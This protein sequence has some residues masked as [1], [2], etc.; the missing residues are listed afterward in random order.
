M[1]MTLRTIRGS[2]LPETAMFISL[3][4]LLVLGAA[5]LTLVG[6][7]QLSAD[8]A[9][10]LGAHAAASN[11]NA[12]PKKVITSIFPQIAASGV[13]TTSPS[14]T[15]VQTVVSRNVSALSIFPGSPSSYPITGADIELQPGTAN[16]TP[17]PFSINIAATLKNYCPS[18]DDC[19]L[20]SN[21]SIYIAQQPSLHGNGVNGQWSEWIC[22]D[23]YFDTINFPA[24]RPAGG[25]AGSAYDPGKKGTVENTIYSWDSGTH[26]CS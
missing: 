18:S 26:A 7:S 10:F 24:T 23:G 17:A 15:A 1:K 20:P 25:L 2:A 12:D 4:L 8:G 16:A 13:T 22:H 3:A 5:Q 21:Y 14:A 19:A 11:P 6:V 9:A